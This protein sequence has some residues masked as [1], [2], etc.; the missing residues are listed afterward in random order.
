MSRKKTRIPSRY[1]RPADLRAPLGDHL[2]E[3][4]MRAAFRLNA[5]AAA[6]RR[7]AVATVES[8]TAVLDRGAGEVE[9]RE[10]V[11]VAIAEQP[12]DGP[13]GR[14]VT[15][16]VIRSGWNASGSRFYGADVLERDVPTVYP[17]GTHVYIDH[18]RL[19]E[20]EDIPERSLQTLAGVFE[21]DPYPVREADG[22]TIMRTTVRVFSPWQPLIR[23]AWQAIGLSINGS[24]RGEY[25]ERDGRE[26]III[27]ALT[28]GQSVD[29]VTQPGAGGR[30]VALMESHRPAPADVVTREAGT[31]GAFVESR[32][33][34]GF[35]E[36][37]DQL[38][39]GGYVTRDERIT[40]SGAIG[41]G[42]A[43]FVARIE[44]DAPQ[45]YQRGRFDG[46]TED[47]ATAEAAETRTAEATAEQTRIALDRAVTAAYG[48]ERRAAWVQD[49]D[50][51]RGLIWF[52]AS[53]LDG[54]GATWQQ[55]YTVTNGAV[56]L[57]GD[58]TEVRART[59]YEPVTVPSPV[60]GPPAPTAT[61]ESTVG[62]P[63]A[64]SNTGPT[65]PETTTK[66]NTMGDKSPEV[67]AREAAEASLAKE[68]TT[69][70]AAELELARY[71]AGDVARPVVEQLLTESDLPEPAKARVRAEYGTAGR[72][73]LIEATR[74]LDETMLRAQV[75]A[76]IKAESTYVAGL[77]E[78]AGAGKVSGHGA[79]PGAGAGMPQTV[80]QQPQA[81][82]GILGLNFGPAAVP[83][84]EAQVKQSAEL[85]ESLVGIYVGRGM[86]RAAAEIAADAA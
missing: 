65:A 42:L 59:V 78:A 18:P 36:I 10:S 64:D 1:E 20:R 48:G 15:V 23:E 31:L 44:K 83:M 61:T 54:P 70:E 5:A 17:K 74:Q 11:G 79:A 32:I 53:N 28:Y 72:W 58:R 51:D 26:G 27:E 30:V 75:G 14:M 63:P 41:D 73:P 50:P 66:E 57:T 9:V 60:D 37:G 35:T 6:D 86:S 25:G 4:G 16:D 84:T 55:T 7:R 56:V 2:R 47:L 3:A 82:G 49:Y 13:T 38:Y 77:L 24:G 33:H 71:R 76:S 85:R 39:A 22:T 29:F 34:L 8:G 67:V 19:S 12:G 43:A 68:K 62:S 45:L 52:Y 69:R 46:P 81:G 40:L 21:A 80:A